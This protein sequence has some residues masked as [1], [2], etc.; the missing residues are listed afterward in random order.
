MAYEILLVESAKGDREDIGKFLESLGYKLTYAKDSKEAVTM[1]EREHPDLVIVEVL[2][3]GPMNGLKTCKH[4]KSLAPDWLKIIVTSKLYQSRAMSKDA[5]EKYKADA[6]YEKPFAMG[7]LIETIHQFIG[8]PPPPKKKAK[9]KKRSK[10]STR[11]KADSASEAVDL[12]TL[13]RKSAEPEKVKSTKEKPSGDEAKPKEPPKPPEPAP[14][15]VQEQDFEEEIEV[16]S[17][18]TLY[19]QPDQFEKQ[20]KINR[21]SLGS[22]LHNIF[23]SKVNGVLLL[24]YPE[25]IKHIFL[26]GGTPVFV[27]SNIRKESLGQILLNEGHISQ[28]QYQEIIEEAAS[29]KRKIGSICVKKGILTSN[30]LHQILSEQTCIKVADCF[31]WD[32]GNYELDTE[33]TYPAN[34]PVFES[35]PA[36]IVL[37]AYADYYPWNILEDNY[38]R[39]SKKIVFSGKEDVYKDIESELTDDQLKFIQSADGRKTLGD[40][41]ES[42]P[43]ARTTI[44]LTYAM[45]AMQVFRLG[46]IGIG[47]ELEDYTPDPAIE[48]S[49]DQT[50]DPISGR[51]NEMYIRIENEDHFKIL[52]L[53]KKA[54]AEDLERRYKRLKQ[55][56]HESILTEESPKPHL[57]KLSAINEALDNAY[58]KLS[59]GKSREN[60]VQSLQK[61]PDDS[62]Q[63]SIDQI[64]TASKHEL[65]ENQISLIAELS[66]QKG[67]HAMAR[68]KYHRAV[69]YFQRATDLN[70]GT[71]EYFIQLGYAIFL[72][73]TRPQNKI[74]EALK[75]INKGLELS[76]EDI[77]VY[78]KLS[79]IEKYRG[80]LG[81]A[82]GYLKKVVKKYPEDGEAELEL[83]ELQER[84]KKVTK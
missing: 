33:R 70:P 81:A 63:I 72:K 9:K 2:I 27:Q 20:G 51:I 22:L 83:K 29:T 66:Y 28:E 31:A 12:S 15:P 47:A 49:A 59:D 16:P 3:S 30:M 18:K 34:A 61:E 46:E 68:S 36:K 48:M 52:G 80:N 60:Y 67:L 50:R 64:D 84:L 62:E 11:I 41:V 65:D 74:E 71:G 39:D 58:Q 78:R 82:V 77:T 26:V 43:E 79:E 24:E 56:F 7:D 37:K 14:P 1:F 23:V 19:D 13:T 25:G 38:G 75:N 5:M 44:R 32:T 53:D 54:T 35:S 17:E 4:L 76:P 6:Y 40:M 69:D 21:E 42:A 57:S 10:K 73:L 45:I 8:T 55:R